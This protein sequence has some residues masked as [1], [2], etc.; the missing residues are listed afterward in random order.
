VGGGCLA[1]RPVDRAVECD[2]GEGGIADDGGDSSVVKVLA[3]V[4]STHQRWITRNDHRA[5]HHG[6]PVSESWESEAEQHSGMSCGVGEPG[7]RGGGG[8]GVR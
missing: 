2:S 5:R 1:R 7:D 4:R 6:S 3:G 8:G